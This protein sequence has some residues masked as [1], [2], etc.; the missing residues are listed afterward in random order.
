MG[1][2][3][4]SALDRLEKALELDAQLG[5]EPER[6]TR[7]ETP[8][9]DP[10]LVA[11]DG[12]EVHAADDV[13]LAQFSADKAVPPTFDPPV[14]PGVDLDLFKLG[15]EPPRFGLE[16]SDVIVKPAAKESAPA[17]PWVR[18]VLTVGLVGALVGAVIGVIGTV[19]FF[20]GGN[21][22]QSLAASLRLPERFLRSEAASP[23]PPPAVARQ[24]AAPQ[25]QPAAPPP[26]A[27]VPTVVD[28]PHVVDAPQPDVTAAPTA[29]KQPPRA[30]A[31][32]RNEPPP[33]VPRPSAPPRAS[34]NAASLNALP[35]ASP[36][37]A[38]L[39]A[40]P[41][42]APT[43]PV[44][45]DPP[46]VTGP[47]VPSPALTS[48]LPNGGLPGPPAS[49]PASDP[50]PVR[51]PPAS[52]VQPST[53]SPPPETSRAATENSAIYL[54]LGR[55]QSAFNDLNASVAK[56][57]WPSVDERVL[58]RAFEGLQQQEILFDAC[59]IAVDGAQAVASCRGRARYVPKVGSK[60]ARLE[61]HHWTFRLRNTGES[62]VIDN[63]ESR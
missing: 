25:L 60:A 58:G 30:G 17:R 12:A 24:E 23:P 62:W 50:A 19:G 20:G 43:V 6:T 51:R 52:S 39:N 28:P 5:R 7:D 36:N 48:A 41:T 15:P 26:V 9:A 46:R 49:P 59:Q 45:R 55:Y 3:P 18:A 8:A 27:D 54:V 21:R 37:A 2:L 53:A 33:S 40:A 47:D 31:P 38:S 11:I 1:R 10:T 57:V 13:W 16:L 29:G 22:F 44:P 35:S 63:V 32:S 4:T 34:P 14:D 56:A 61:P 42:G